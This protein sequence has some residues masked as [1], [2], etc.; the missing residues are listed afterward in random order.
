M[1]GLFNAEEAKTEATEGLLII[2]VEVCQQN[3]HFWHWIHYIC[4]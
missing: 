2:C 3:T 4:I 1:I